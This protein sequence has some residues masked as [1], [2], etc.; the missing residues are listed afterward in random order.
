[1][2]KDQAVVSQVDERT[3]QVC[4]ILQSMTIVNSV[5]TKKDNQPP[6]TS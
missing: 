6:R 2:N 4:Q 3:H 1:M 5:E